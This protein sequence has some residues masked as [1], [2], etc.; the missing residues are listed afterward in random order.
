MVL[1]I[2][3][4]KHGKTAVIKLFI[5][6]EINMSSEKLALLPVSDPALI[7]SPLFEGMDQQ[8]I[9]VAAA[10]FEQMS[11]KKGGVV[12]QEGDVGDSLFILLSG[13]LGAYVSQPDGTQRRM[14]EIGPGDFFGEMSIIANEPRSATLTATEDTELMALPGI[15]FF[16]IIFDHPMI[17]LKM[18]KAIS[19]AQNVWLDQTS[20]HLTDLTRWGE[21]ARRRAITDEMTGLYNR[22]FLEES[23]NDRFE[24][25][26]VGIRTM[27]LLII[28]VDRMHEINERHGSPAGDYVL[29]IVADILH[30]CTRAADIA[31][32]F[33][34]DEFGIFL[35]DTGIEEALTSAQRIREIVADRKISVPT[36]PDIVKRVEINIYISIGVAVAPAH[37]INRETLF[38]AADN[39]LFV[40]KEKGRNRVELAGK[41]D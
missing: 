26:S 10:F 2:F 11:I 7:G 20:R 38:R 12:F 14:F 16:R 34:G 33:S 29:M 1:K 41:D 9:N 6:Q 15:D 18:L 24:Q 31:A 30:S 22:R 32:R 17:G 28:D 37:A 27:A 25:G 5:T 8:E 23:I 35:P 19:R 40:A 21:S 4:L 3:F 36:T 13:D 39:A